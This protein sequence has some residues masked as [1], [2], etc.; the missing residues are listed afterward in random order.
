M[1]VLNTHNVDRLTRKKINDWLHYVRGKFITEKRRD[2]VQA[3]SIDWQS[4]DSMRDFASNYQIE[5]ETILVLEIPVRELESIA[6]TQEWYQ[7]NIG[8]YSMEKFDHII[9]NKHMEESLREKH[10][11]LQE[12]WEQYQVLLALCS[13][14]TFN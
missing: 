7:A 10:P 1:D 4:P 11:G 6:K 12:A 2:V 8:G 3:K 14:Q 9:R 5:T 13:D